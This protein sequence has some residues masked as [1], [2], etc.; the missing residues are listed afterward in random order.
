MAFVYD[1]TLQLAVHCSTIVG[2][3]NPNSVTRQSEPPHPE[4]HARLE[5]TT[6][7]IHSVKLHRVK[8]NCYT[9]PA[10]QADVLT[11]YMQTYKLEITSLQT[12]FFFQYSKRFRIA[13]T[14]CPISCALTASISS[15]CEAEDAAGQ[16]SDLAATGLASSAGHEQRCLPRPRYRAASRTAPER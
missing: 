9:S 11:L 13:T 16:G 3:Q 4:L 1:R 6:L 10:S 2:G 15:S 12:Y 5:E 7:F 8:R 14:V